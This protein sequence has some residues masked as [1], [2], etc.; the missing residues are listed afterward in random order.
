MARVPRLL[1]VLATLLLLFGTAMHG[2]AFTKTSTVVAGS[3]LPVFFGGSLKAF[4]LNDC[5]AMLILAALLALLAAKPAMGSR[6][7]VLLLALFPAAIGVLLYVFIGPFFAAPF[8]LAI[9]A[10]IFLG[11]LFWP[12]QSEIRP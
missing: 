6:G 10:L 3:D 2:S 12:R 7:I 4:W 9:A 5:A 1:L 11:G 8:N